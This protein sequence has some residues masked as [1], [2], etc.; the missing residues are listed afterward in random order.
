MGLEVPRKPAQAF[1]KDR[2]VDAAHKLVPVIDVENQDPV[3]RAAFFLR[4]VR[5]AHVEITPGGRLAQGHDCDR[6]KNCEEGH[7]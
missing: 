4:R 2:D 5:G 3:T 7:E 1:F 6:K